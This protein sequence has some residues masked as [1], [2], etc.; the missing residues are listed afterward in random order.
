M[1]RQPNGPNPGG[2]TLED[3]IRARLKRVDS[4]NYARNSKFVLTD[5][6]EFVRDRGIRELEN[7][8]ETDCRRYAQDLADR[9]DADELAA[10]SANT[11][12]NIV[13][14]WLAWCVR[15]ARIPENPAEKLRAT[16]ELPEDQGDSDRQY[17][18]ADVR[19]RLL[20]HMDKVVDEANEANDRRAQLEAHRNRALVYMLAYSGA[21]GAEI[22]RDPDDDD[23]NGICWSDVDVDAGV[24]GVLGKTR[25]RQEVSILEPARTRLE[26]YKRLLDPPESWPVF[27]TF[28]PPN[29]YSHVREAADGD[30]DTALETEGPLT[31]MRDQGIG[32]RAISVQATRNLMQKH[33]KTAGIDIDGEYLKPHGGRRGLGHELYAEQAE[34]AQ[35]MLCHQNIGTTHESYRE[36][37]AA[38]RKEAAEGALFDNSGSSEDSSPP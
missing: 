30:L 13:R 18:S 28:H 4:G 20:A 9:V 33:C 31:V 25:E 35:E 21:R 15:D 7:V 14:A 6:A 26:R 23:R 29:L 24:V 17:W 16:E 19:D 34:L 3:A 1:E 10:S 8:T 11:Y 37:R 5:F 2:G 32:P 36:V 38:E 12:Y 27:M 22:V